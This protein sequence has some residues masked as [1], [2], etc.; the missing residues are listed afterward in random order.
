MTRKFRCLLATPNPFFYFFTDCLPA[1]C[2]SAM[3]ETVEVVELLPHFCS[4]CG[5]TIP[6]ASQSLHDDHDLTD[7]VVLCLEETVVWQRE[8]VVEV[9]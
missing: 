2:N 6:A 5:L 8:I 7:A 3:I 4:N 1:F 9:L